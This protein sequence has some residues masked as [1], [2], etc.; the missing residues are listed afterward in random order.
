MKRDCI[1]HGLCAHCA[2]EFFC[3]PSR[4]ILCDICNATKKKDMSVARHA[5][6][7]KPSK[8]RVLRK[9]NMN[10]MRKSRDRYLVLRNIFCSDDVPSDFFEWVQTMANSSS[11]KKQ[12]IVNTEDKKQP[13][14][15]RVQVYLDDF[16]DFCNRKGA[17]HVKENSKRLFEKI[18]AAVNELCGDWRDTLVKL[19]FNA[20]NSYDL[21]IQD[22]HFDFP[23]G[24][25]SGKETVLE[26]LSIF[27]TLDPA[28]YD[29]VVS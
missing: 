1:M 17:K 18:K 15:K 13:S 10:N 11:K 9:S 4:R 2:Q 29:L 22:E 6:A 8:S 28:G 16:F 21:E 7:Y 14:G 23:E 27:A 5:R 20:N 12:Y 19:I 26:D 3:K 25:D 24:R